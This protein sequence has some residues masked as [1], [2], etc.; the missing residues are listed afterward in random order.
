VPETHPTPEFAIV[1]DDLT[2]DAVD[3]L[4]ALLIELAG[5]GEGADDESR[6]DAA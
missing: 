1:G 3:A 4:A 2:D 5:E 6:E